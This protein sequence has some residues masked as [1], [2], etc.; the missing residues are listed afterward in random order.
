MHAAVAHILNGH[1]RH[2][3]RVMAGVA[4]IEKDNHGVLRSLGTLIAT[5]FPEWSLGERPPLLNPTHTR[6]CNFQGLR[7]P[8][9]GVLAV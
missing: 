1:T 4:Y 6:H 8:A 3:L 9:R 2:H 5:I 7:Q